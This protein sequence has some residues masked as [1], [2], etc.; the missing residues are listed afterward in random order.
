MYQVWHGEETQDTNFTKIN[1]VYNSKHILYISVHH[2]IAC[3]C[4]VPER[5]WT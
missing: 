4:L 1:D 5:G 2:I 3:L